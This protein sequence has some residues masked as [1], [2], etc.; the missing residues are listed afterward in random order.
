MKPILFST[1]MVQ[2]ILEGRKTVTRRVI[3]PP[4]WASEDVNDIEIQDNQAVT[5]CKKTGCF[6]VINSPYKVG[7]VLYVRE[8]WCT[9]NEINDNAFDSDLIPGYYYKVTDDGKIPYFNTDKDV[10]SGWKPSIH[11]PKELARIFLKVTD[12]QVE[13]LQDITEEQ[14][15]K[16]GIINP[17]TICNC[18]NTFSECDTCIRGG[19]S[20]KD[21]FLNY[22]DEL[23]YKS[24]KTRFKTSENYSKYNPWVWAIEFE[25]CEKES[26]GDGE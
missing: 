1:A 5:I 20:T 13:R 25:R 22:W 24:D 17:C 6:A 21:I 4:K 23:I 9:H 8:T 14:A 11:M 26:E 3:K 10:I 7:D 2:A 16:E 19:I 15:I 12:V 18:T